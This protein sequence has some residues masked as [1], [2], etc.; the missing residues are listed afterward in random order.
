[1]LCL[2][3]FAVAA[4]VVAVGVAV[5]VGGGGGG[6]NVTLPTRRETRGG[7]VRQNPSILQVL[8]FKYL[9]MTMNLSRIQLK[10]ADPI[11]P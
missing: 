11:S 9:E 8:N 4:D 1:M 6:A 7:T 2:L 3:F 10:P 5:V